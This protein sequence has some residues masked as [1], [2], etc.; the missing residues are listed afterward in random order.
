MLD[1]VRRWIWEAV[2]EFGDD[3]PNIERYVHQKLSGLNP[4]D[5]ARLMDE[6]DAMRSGETGATH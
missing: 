2:A 1:E 3:W 4:A 6:F 5:R